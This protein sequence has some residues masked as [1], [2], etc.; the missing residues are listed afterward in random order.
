M[1]CVL[2]G[3]LIHY[4]TAPITDL[5]I[6]DWPILEKAESLSYAQLVSTGLRDVF[7]PLYN[8]YMWTAFKLIGDRPLLYSAIR[9]GMTGFLFLAVLFF[10]V[11]YAGGWSRGVMGLIMFFLFPVMSQSY[12]WHAHSLLLYI[13][14]LYL[15][16]LVFWDVWLEKTKIQWFIFSVLCYAMALF[17]YEYGVFLFPLFGAWAFIKKGRFLVRWS[18]VFAGAAGVYLLWRSTGGFG[19]GEYTI[20]GKQYFSDGAFRVVDIAQNIRHILSW[21]TGRNFWQEIQSGLAG[22]LLLS[23]KIQFFF[24]V[25]NM[26]ILLVLRYLVKKRNV[27]QENTGSR[28]RMCLF[29]MLFVAC[30]YAP[31]LFFRCSSRHNLFP[32]V[33]ISMLLVLLAGRV[34]WNPGGL[35]VAPALLL[36]VVNQGHGL[37]WRDSGI[38]H[39]RIY[40]SLLATQPEWQNKKALVVDTRSLRQ[41]MTGGLLEQPSNWETYG[42]AVLPRGWVYSAMMKRILKDGDVPQVVLDMECG[43]EIGESRV[44]WHPRFDPGGDAQELSLSEIAIY[45]CYSQRFLLQNE[46]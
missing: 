4:G 43:A 20:V 15:F 42:V 32:A 13:P 38:F 3:W 24:I 2:A 40:N 30:A 11:R 26:F 14:V 12:C 18:G 9:I 31:Y 25:S 44:T 46:F 6:D 45:N 19:I 1:W 39:R 37:Q 5:V 27:D 34:K 36:M 22:F 41:R 23:P 16:S 21:W 35:W 17:S 28:G 10:G 33:G 29:F 8:S 7:R